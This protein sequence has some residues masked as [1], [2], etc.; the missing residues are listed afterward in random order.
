M[1]N[2]PTNKHF[3]RLSLAAILFS[4]SAIPAWYVL[5]PGPEI[6]GSLNSAEGVSF[7]VAS[8]MSEPSTDFG[9]HGLRRQPG[10]PATPDIL[11]VPVAPSAPFPM[12]ATE[13][14]QAAYKHS[15]SVDRE[16]SRGKVLPPRYSS[17]MIMQV[18]SGPPLLAYTPATPDQA[19]STRLINPDLPGNSLPAGSERVAI[20]AIREESEDSEASFDVSILSSPDSPPDRGSITSIYHD[21]A[22][23]VGF[24]AEE[25]ASRARW[26]WD[27]WRR[28][29]QVAHLVKAGRL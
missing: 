8:I 28:L 19:E 15:E 29:Q 17:S 13:R 18:A 23:G 10:G 14:T 20:E 11:R 1:F 16:A 12:L 7:S 6:S 25:E 27:G 4:A 26:G 24:T 5:T 9:F 22:H 21:I 3:A 2:R